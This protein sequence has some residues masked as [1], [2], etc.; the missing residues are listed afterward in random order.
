MLEVFI[1][2]LVG[3]LHCAGMCG[4]IAFSLP[5]GKGQMTFLIG[6]ILYNSGRIVT[7]SIL[8]G[9][10]AMIGVGARFFQVQQALSIALG[11]ILLIWGVREL[12]LIKPLPQIKAIDRLQAGIR[13]GFTTVL[14]KG[15]P[16]SLFQVGLINGILPCGFVYMGL[17]YAV[18]SANPVQGMISMALFGLGTFPVM[19]VLSLSSSMLTQRLRSRINGLI[20]YTILLMGALFVVRGLALGIPYLSPALTFDEYGKAIMTCCGN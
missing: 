2:G 19:F 18:L 8:G 6:R 16:L 10:V 20:P 9:L 11:L 5:R 3:S 4:P 15:G 12:G 14:G 1:L 7:Y 13:S 17:F